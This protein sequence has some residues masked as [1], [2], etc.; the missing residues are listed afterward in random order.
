MNIHRQTGVSRKTIY[1][2]KSKIKE[3]VG[4][5]KCSTYR[6]ENI[7]SGKCVNLEFNHNGEIYVCY[8]DKK[9]RFEKKT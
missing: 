8:S 4:F 3:K 6:A 1:Q 5:K 7:K 2:I 9:D